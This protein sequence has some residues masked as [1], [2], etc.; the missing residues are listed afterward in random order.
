MLLGAKNDAFT[1]QIHSQGTLYVSPNIGNKDTVEHGYND[2]VYN[3][4]M[5]IANKICG[6]IWSQMVTLQHKPSRL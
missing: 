4:F 1:Y 5:V 6:I 3:E 2:H